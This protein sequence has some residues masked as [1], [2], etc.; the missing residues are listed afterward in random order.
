MSFDHPSFGKIDASRVIIFDTTLRDGEQ[1]PGFSMNLAEK[2]RMAEALATLGVDVIEAGF[3]VASKGDFESVNQIARHTKGSVICALAR[4]GGAKDIAAAG[5][6]LAQAER[7]RIH[8]FISTSPLHMKYKLRMEP[9]TVLEL[10]TTGN[11]AARNLTDDVEWSAEDGS[12]TDPDFLCRCVEAAIKAGAT[13]INIPDTVGYA[14]PEDMLRIFSMLRERVPGA[15]QVIFSAHNHNDLGLAVANT[16]ASVEGGARQIECTINGIGERAGNAALEEIVMALRTRNDQYPFTTGINTPDLL[17]VSRM[18]ATITSFDVQPNKAIVGRNA[19]AH[20]SGIHQDGVLKNAATYEIM[21]PESVGWTRSSLVMGKHSGRAAFRDKLKSLG[22]DSLDDAKLNDAFSRFK[23]LADRKKA[24]Y[25]EDII[26]LV[27]DEVRDH[28][29][30]RFE[31][32]KLASVSGQPSDAE[33]TLNVEGKVITSQAI[34]NGPVDAAFNALQA[35]FPHDA[36]LA[37]FSVAAVT[38][39]TDAQARTSV[40]LEE[41]GKMVDGQGADADTVVSA[42]RAYVHALNK[43][44]IKRDRTEPEA[45]TV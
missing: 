27:D 16:L 19:F 28:A 38:E 12:R 18:L 5:E 22:Y 37:L 21:T 14:T 30:I 33:L 43:L 6:A 39:G 15:D 34:G 17:K 25:D 44:L 36:R 9:E 4:T 29:H 10:I 13:T 41:D 31:H 1:S 26:A 3:P 20:E 42:V 11:T 35:A 40:R 7:K 45:L 8:N 32:L 23:D 24:V 2:L